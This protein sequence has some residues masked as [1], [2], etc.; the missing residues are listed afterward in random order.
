MNTTNIIAGIIVILILCSPFALIYWIVKKIKQRRGQKALN[1][2]QEHSSK[3]ES[4]TRV[5]NIK[6]HSEIIT[7][8]S[9]ISDPIISEHQIDF[10][11]RLM[12][13]IKNALSNYDFVRKDKI[14][15]LADELIHNN[16]KYSK[17]ILSLE[18]KRSLNLNTRSKYAKEFIDCFVG[19]GSFDFDPKFFCE[20]LKHTERSIL[21]CLDEIERLKKLK[22]VK[23]VSLEGKGEWDE[24]ICNIEDIPE[25]DTID[26]TE[27]R[28]IF[29]ICS[30]ID[31]NDVIDTSNI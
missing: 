15:F 12:L 20:N 23:K 14:S 5:P 6:L 21:W 4:Q 10:E 3:E 16:L 17:N 18:E 28:V 1:D 30:K 9:N 25:M 19:I 11:K 31:L 29:F 8:P 13:R 27:E 2:Y 24:K 7:T 22:F 26:Y